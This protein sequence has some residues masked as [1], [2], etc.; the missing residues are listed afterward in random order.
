MLA[1]AVLVVFSMP[2]GLA[3]TAKDREIIEPADINAFVR[4]TTETEFYALAYLSLL[5]HSFFSIGF[6][7]FLTEESY[8]V[9]DADFSQSVDITDAFQFLTWDSY[10]R[11]TGSYPPEAEAYM[12][13]RVSMTTPVVTT[14]TE[15]T[16]STENPVGT[17][18]TGSDTTDDPALSTTEET[19][20]T[21]TTIST[22]TTRTTATTK[23]ATTTSAT[24][25]V[26]KA[27]YDGIDVSKY[28]LDVDWTKVKK[29]GKDFAIIR[30]GYGKYASQE[31]PY[32][33]QNMKNAKA[34]GLSCGAYWFSYA[35]SVASAKQ[36]AEVF[37]SVIEGYQFDYPLVFDIEAEVHAKMTKEQVSAIIE[38]FCDTMESK[39]YFVT[40]YSYA[41]F[42]NSKVYD[43]VLEKYDVWVAHFNVDS[44]SY[45]KSYGM[46]QYSSTGS[47]SG[48]KGDV[49]MD[50]SYRNYPAIIKNA[51]L[52]G[53]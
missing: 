2:S 17:D 42:L 22:T 18:V 28:Q 11:L 40:V 43:S 35:D 50:Y 1:A 25:T 21:T 6:D 24:T 14:V 12:A 51:H 16:V 34:A 23:A 9:L 19:T 44:P 39:G 47:V 36:E 26:K 4:E 49:D 37:A 3:V 53:F 10:C 20:V 15:I 8:M 45:T 27:V 7:S 29:N 38:A 46:W 32:F 48:I 33:A 41:S 5:T 31:D 52:N 30:A 13:Q